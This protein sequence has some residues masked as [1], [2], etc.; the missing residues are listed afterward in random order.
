M[1]YWTEERNTPTPRGRGKNAL[2]A[3]SSVRVLLIEPNETLQDLNEQILDL[4]GYHV[5][6][7]PPH[8][9]LVPYVEQNRPEVIVLGA[10]PNEPD[11]LKL[12]ELLQANPQTRKI[13]VVVITTNP[14]IGASAKAI[15]VARDLIVAPYD[16]DALANA[17]KSALQNPPPAAALPVPKTIPAEAI[18]Y[19][20]TELA[21]HAHEIVLRAI[22]DLQTREAYRSRFRSLSPG[23]V[24][25]LATIFSAINTGVGRALTPEQ[26]FLNT[27]I[28]EA[29]TKHDAERQK[30]G[31]SV[32]LIV[33]E[34]EVLANEMEDFV[35][36]LVGQDQFTAADALYVTQRI[37]KYLQE[38][39]RVALQNL[40]SP[41]K[42]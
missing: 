35:A 39:I 21:R 2:M 41:G 34:Y 36:K 25:H 27:T 7:P 28:H 3:Q 19:A 14:A 18:T 10:R 17:V 26:V 20:T 8:A 15:P 29:I 12:L 22:Q 9:D 31:V 23:L 42:P 24:D 32:A 4:F 38:L 1:V 11:D 5:Q 13:P 33:W 6:T 37:H 16:I 30:D 40:Q